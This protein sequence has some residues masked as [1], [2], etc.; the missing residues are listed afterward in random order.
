MWQEFNTGISDNITEVLMMHFVMVLCSKL[1]ITKFILEKLN[2]YPHYQ[3]S[4][5]HQNL[6]L[7]I[8][9]VPILWYY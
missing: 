5:P 8:D 3:Q 7:N 4:Y 2:S 6:K 9:I 1:K